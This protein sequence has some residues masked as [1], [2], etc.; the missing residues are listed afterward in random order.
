MFSDPIKKNKKTGRQK[1][2]SHTTVPREHNAL[3]K[4]ARSLLSNTN[5]NTENILIF[6][7]TEVIK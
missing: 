4:E 2:I 5:S 7:P 3:T 6:T 1:G